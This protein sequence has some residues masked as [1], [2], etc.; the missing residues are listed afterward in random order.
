MY[1]VSYKSQVSQHDAIAINQDFMVAAVHKLIKHCF[2]QAYKHPSLSHRVVT[3][4]SNSVSGNEYFQAIDTSGRPCHYRQWD[5]ISMQKAMMEVDK[6]QTIRKAAEMFGVPRSSLHDCVA[7]RIQHGSQA[8]RLPYLTPE[9]EEELVQFLIKCA[10][11][12]YPHTRAQAL[13]LA[14]QI[15]DQKG[16]KQIITFGWWQKFCQRHKNLT[17]RSAANLSIQRAMATDRDALNLYYN[18]LEDTLKGNGI[19]NKPMH[20]FNCDETGMPLNPKGVKVIA[21]MGSKNPSCITGDTKSQITVLACVSANGYSIPPFVIFDRKTL[22]PELTIGEVPGTLYGLSGNGWITRDLFH[23]WF[24]H[25][26]LAYA[27]KSRPLLLLMDGHSTHYCPEAIRIAAKENVILFTLPPHT[28]HLTQP[29]DKGCFGPL[30][31]FWKE[32]CHDFCTRNPGRV[33]T[34]YDFS[35]LFAKTWFQSMSAPNILAGFRTCGVCPFSRTA[36]PVLRKENLFQPELLSEDT[37]L[38]YIP[39]YSPACVCQSRPTSMDASFSSSPTHTSTPQQLSSR[40]SSSQENIHF[41]PVAFSEHS[42]LER[43]LSEGDI[44]VASNSGCFSY[45]KRTSSITNLLSTPVHPRKCLTVKRGKSVG[46]VLTS[47]ENL[48][49]IAEKEKEK[50]KFLLQKEVRRAER[51]A[52]A[53][54]K[55][56]RLTKVREEKATVSCKSKRKM[57]GM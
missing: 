44:N 33:V 31:V 38:A 39:L 3:T 10:D 40:F 15:V 37:G 19:L 57:G 5:S 2:M 14:Q 21:R 4:H 28:T 46:Q 22:N 30:K 35:K 18:M 49:L 12:G 42:S 8:G 27:P 11:I 13:A 29:L 9:E 52:K 34:R 50:Q 17:L 20:I 6:G 1:V 23:H 32:T 56:D 47:A 51:E 7:G 54:A 55:A 41:S 16:I 48:H 25:H 43:S 45:S 26:F 36:L 53:K 24:K